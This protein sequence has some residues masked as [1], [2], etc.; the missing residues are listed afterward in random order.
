L[1]FAHCSSRKKGDIATILAAIREKV[2][3]G[4]RR[5]QPSKAVLSS[6]YVDDYLVEALAVG[7]AFGIPR[8]SGASKRLPVVGPDCGPRKLLILSQ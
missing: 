7:R 4:T 3:F 6:F 5:S 2:S 8:A 1:Q